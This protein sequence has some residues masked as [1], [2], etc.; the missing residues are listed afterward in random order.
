[1]HTPQVST[2]TAR[3]NE[4]LREMFSAYGE[5][6]D[7]YMPRN[8]A[9]GHSRGFGFVRFREEAEAEAAMK[10]CDGVVIDGSAPLHI[11]SAPPHL[12][13]SA[14]PRLCA[15]APLHLHTAAPLHLRSCT[16]L[17]LASASASAPLPSRRRD[18]RVSIA[19]ARARRCQRAG[20]PSGRPAGYGGYGGYSGYSDRD[21]AIGAAAIAAATGTAT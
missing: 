14:P 1:M 16:P 15:S 20:P 21:P 3:R 18:L 19:R 7:C 5:V 4:A 2:R 13:T 9:T 10:G 17:H 12:R 8:H 6:A 11:A